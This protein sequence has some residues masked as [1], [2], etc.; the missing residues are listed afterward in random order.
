MSAVPQYD[1]DQS[2][3]WETEV[4]VVVLPPAAGAAKTINVPYAVEWQVLSCT[5]KLVTSSQAATRI[6]EYVVLDQT[7]KPI[8]AVPQLYTVAA[9]KTTVCTFGV[10]LDTSGV[11]D[12]AYVCVAISPMWLQGGYQIKLDV[13]A[14]DSGDQI[15]DIR[16][17]VRQRNVTPLINE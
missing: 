11:N 3:L 9:S 8:H 12:G 1:V 16:L 6:V 2:R 4:P 14:I 13:A 5:L 17:H 7:G 15:S 10:G